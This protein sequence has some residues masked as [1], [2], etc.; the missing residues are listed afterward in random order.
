MELTIAIVGLLTA[1]LGL[2]TAALR[3]VHKAQGGSH[4]KKDR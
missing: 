4:K 1:L 3:F 2:A